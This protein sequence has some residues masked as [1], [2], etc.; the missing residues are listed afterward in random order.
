[1]PKLSGDDKINVKVFDSREVLYLAAFN[2]LSE[3]SFV[4][5]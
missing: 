2:D 5:Q 1:M 4:A 3:Q